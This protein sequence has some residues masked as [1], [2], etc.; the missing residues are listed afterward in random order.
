MVF[1]NETGARMRAPV[2][3]PCPEGCV[4]ELW[5]FRNTA[6]RAKPTEKLDTGYGAKGENVSVLS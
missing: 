5:I 1:H 3:A 2:H 4:T 6:A